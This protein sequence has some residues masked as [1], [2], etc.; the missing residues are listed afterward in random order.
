MSKFDF[1]IFISILTDFLLI[2]FVKAIV[3]SINFLS[4]SVAEG[5]HFQDF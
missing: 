2:N 1:V 3:F 5:K 4:L